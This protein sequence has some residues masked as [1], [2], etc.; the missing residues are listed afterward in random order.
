MMEYSKLKTEISSFLDD[1]EDDL[2][3]P[4]WNGYGAEPIT[5]VAMK[6]AYM[7]ANAMDKGEVFVAPLTSGGIQF[8]WEDKDGNYFEIEINPDGTTECG[9]FSIK[10]RGI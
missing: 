9:A 6:K 10:E 5:M 7:I 8:E 2:W 4:N 1:F 3:E